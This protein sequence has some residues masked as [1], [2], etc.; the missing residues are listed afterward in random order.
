MEGS[1]WESSRSDWQEWTVH[2]HEERPGAFSGATVLDL[3]GAVQR[4]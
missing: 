4:S 3:G 1:S 2:P